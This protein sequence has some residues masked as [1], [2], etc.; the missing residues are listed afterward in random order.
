MTQNR[1]C[2]ERKERKFCTI[3]NITSQ[4]VQQV[5]I[6]IKGITINCHGLVVVVAIITF[7]FCNILVIF[8]ETSLGNQ[9]LL[10]TFIDNIKVLHTKFRNVSINFEA[11]FLLKFGSLQMCVLRTRLYPTLYTYYQFN[12]NNSIMESDIYEHH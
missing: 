9:Y 3:L 5:N 4:F 6:N 7:K 12:K 1:N 2:S 11:W 8:L 10:F